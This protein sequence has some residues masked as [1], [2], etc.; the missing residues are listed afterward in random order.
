MPVAIDTT[1]RPL[2][3]LSLVGDE[4]RVN[5]T[6]AS[7]QTDPALTALPAGGYAIVW[8][9]YYQDGS[10]YG[11]YGQRYDAAGTAIG[12][13]FRVNKYTTAS[14]DNPAVAAFA[15]D[16]LIV[17]WQSYG[18]DG[19]DYGI[20]GQ[21]YD[22]I[23]TALG[24]EFRPNR[25]TAAA[26]SNPAVATL[27]NGGYVIVWQ[28]AGNQDGNGTGVYGRLYDSDGD[29]VGTEF[30]V[31]SYTTGDQS[32]PTVTA[33]ASG[34]FIV[35]WQSS[36]QDYKMYGQRYDGDGLTIGSEF[37]ITNTTDRLT[38]NKALLSYG[39][40][41]VVT[42]DGD[43][44]LYQLYGSSA[45]AI[46]GAIRINS[47]IPSTQD[48]PVI[49]T[50][51]DGSSLV[52]WRSY[53][54]DGSEHGIYS[55]R[56][57]Y[58][59][60][61]RFDSA[62]DSG[63]SN[64]D[65]IT[66]LTSGLTFSSV[67]E[68]QASVTLF[69]D[70]NGNDR[71]DTGETLTTSLITSANSVYL[72]D[73]TLTE[74]SHAIKA[75]QTDLAGHVS[76]ATAPLLLT[77]DMT[78]P[79]APTGLH[80]DAADDDTSPV[81]DNSTSRSTVAVIGGGREKGAMVALWSG[82]LL[83]NSTT[84]TS[85]DGS[86]SIEL[87]RLEP[88][89]YPLTAI[90]TDVAGNVSVASASVKL[91]IVEDTVAPA[92]P[93][94][95]DLAAADD[96]LLSN[97]DDITSYTSGLT[98][99]GRGESGS[100]LRLFEDLNNNGLLEPGEALTT[101]L[102]VNKGWSAD[103]T[104]P[105]VGSHNIRAIQ[106][107]AAGNTS[108]ASSGLLL[109]IQAANRIPTVGAISRVGDQD[110]PLPFA[111]S[112]FSSQ[113][114]D[115]DGDAMVM[116]KIT[117][118]PS[119][120]TLTLNGKAVAVGQQIVTKDLDALLFT[121][122]AG[123]SGSTS[124]QWQGFDNTDW[125]ST[126]ALVT[127]TINA[128]SLPE[129]PTAL[130]LLAADDSGLSA[131]DRITNKTSLTLSGSGR[132]GATLT[133]FDGG[134]NKGTLT[135]GNSGSWNLVV[136]GLSDGNHAFTATQTTKN[137]TSPAS[138]VLNVKVDTS[139]PEL[140]FTKPALSTVNQLLTIS[141]SSSD[142]GS[143]VTQVEL[144]IQ[145]VSTGRYMAY[146]NGVWNDRGQSSDWKAAEPVSA[147]NW[148]SW[149]LDTGNIW[150]PGDSYQLTVKARDTAGNDSSSTTTFG[151]GDPVNTR[152]KLDQS[153]YTIKS[154]QANQ[155]VT[156]SGQ[157]QRQD[158]N[159]WG[160]DMSGQTIQLIITDTNNSERTLRAT[161]DSRGLFRFDNINGFNGA[162]TYKVKVGYAH[163]TSL[164]I[165]PATTYTDVRV[166]PPVGYA[167]VVQ[168]Q[169]IGTDGKPEGLDDH[170]RST[171]RIYQTLLSRG[172]TA[173]DINYFSFD[174]GDK[175]G[176]NLVTPQPVTR[177]ELK[178]AIEDWAFT[179]MT[180]AAAPL[181]LIMV[182][183]GDPDVFYIGENSSSG[184]V[185][186]QELSS[187]M[188]NLDTNLSKAGEA[189]KLALAQQQTVIVGS[190]YSGSFIDDLSRDSVNNKQRMVITSATAMERSNRGAQEPDGIRDGELF[191]HY[192][193]Q[194]LGQGATF[195]A[196]FN[197]ATRLTEADP[198]VNVNLADALR[199]SPKDRIMEKIS[200]E[201]GQHPLLNDN[202]DD[203]GSNELTTQVGEDGAI[204]SG[205]R[206]GD[207]LSSTT[208]AVAGQM[209]I[210]S[211]AP[212]VYDVSGTASLWVKTTSKGEP[213]SKDR[214]WVTVIRPDVPKS[215]T[216]TNLQ[217]SLNLPTA[218]M[219]FD[220]S[221]QRWQ[222]D[223]NK[224]I[225]FTGFDQ[226]GRYQFQYTLMDGASG[227]TS[228]SVIGSVYKSKA[229]NHQP[230]TV[231]LQTPATGEPVSRIGLF[232]WSDAVDP[233]KDAVTYNLVISKDQAGTNVAYRQENLKLSQLL[234]D[235]KDVLEAGSYWWHVETV[236]YYGLSSSSIAAAMTLTFQN[237]I[238]AVLR[239]LVYSNGDYSAITGAT[240]TLN[241]KVL[242]SSESNGSLQA[243]I[244]TG[245]GTLRVEKEGYQTYSASLAPVRAGSVSEL[246]IALVKG[247]SSTVPAP[248]KLDLDYKDDSGS[249]SSDNLTRNTSALTIS[250]VGKK[251]SVVTLFDDKNN[252]GQFDNG[253]LLGTISVTAATGAWTS[254]DLT[255]AAGTH[256]LR[257]TQKSGTSISAASD[258]L[259]IT[260]DTTAPAAAP[261]APVL[262]T[263]DD[264][265]VR[266]NITTKSKGLNFS[267]T[268]DIGAMV[269]LFEDKNKNK[270][271]DSAE[272]A[273]ATVT[274][275]N[276][277]R[278]RTGDLALALGA[279][280]L[281]AFQSDVAGNASVS[282]AVL[283][284]TIAKTAK[285]AELRE[286]SGLLAL[287][288]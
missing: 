205:L 251:G 181:Y 5:T 253:E 84:V 135:I 137:G 274:A 15:N 153:L 192:L 18:Q 48:Q 2:S 241:G 74:G 150:A 267:G 257:A 118:L 261:S 243:L 215:D 80:L 123:W 284:L 146:K 111:A 287:G 39:E 193:F 139:K 239:G 28:S 98:I 282:S 62:D 44:V 228:A 286:G 70:Q 66:K 249:S 248:T 103:I 240:I 7:Y 272:K 214:V 256:T 79:T 64:S 204:S 116:I 168:G 224:I 45:A 185:T 188:N 225:G 279:H 158:G 36:G 43:N 141:G 89:S 144:Q 102:V 220:S 122:V 3:L 174:T 13:E 117:S 23:G 65:R 100:T 221:T 191:L 189:G 14:Q 195:Y 159:D 119:T 227:A 132:P 217:I 270:K 77:V 167:I 138:A 201:A 26:Q 197:E 109:T 76:T 121:P 128:P 166:G 212:T 155:S 208:N 148:Q 71:I 16:G 230:G 275:G 196:A 276:D 97:S 47:Y 237:D 94:E 180:T 54:Q 281:Y 82:N 233:D 202:D 259:L 149:N 17:V 242:S 147:G 63:S 57:N 85:D 268:A 52:V 254:K 210:S 59:A 69:D 50:L 9:S 288:S 207:T 46:D 127:L 247:S 209:Q 262:D 165:K 99:T 96:S 35:T 72:Q 41:A 136:G 263:D 134:S 203:Y 33:L 280:S 68:I 31:N 53:G 229:N 78:V 40:Q 129:A 160:Q 161:T 105:V 4:S 101:T 22:S 21:R 177:T 231:S 199:N 90:Q 133:L 250:G 113:F 164:L 211:V 187:W 61:L 171:N 10:E 178:K 255:L 81:G 151:Y 104:L 25:Q 157:L 223:S 114:T 67:G 91:K 24:N 75:I 264:S 88:G 283:T 73:V 278:W 106:T 37:L 258:S 95:L 236:D 186:A 252:N 235:F 172:F 27:T 200:D 140:T 198:L 152:I 156:I 83:L 145:D 269:T 169:F 143:G 87:A 245:G 60:R 11:V 277:G 51:K 131:S 19:S 108:G 58:Q 38:D 12:S 219:S 218:N 244:P 92:A 125:S 86:W 222:I 182:D 124:F 32:S 163:A 273:L 190:C 184:K 1:I 238:P 8:P 285:Q 29:V 107:D 260:I 120:G 234:V 246:A 30:L 42:S 110:S 232:N 226:P 162:G 115:S 49:A 213:S 216:A 179:R 173:E 6:T 271:Q 56:L 175:V 130:T 20:Y 112:H 170:K 142:L 126:A 183:H 206:L 266:D 176:T 154:N 55:Q 194:Q 265:G 93:T 34:G